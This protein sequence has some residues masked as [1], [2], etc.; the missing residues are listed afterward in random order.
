[1]SIL[2]ALVVMVYFCDREY[3][4]KL[5][6]ELVNGLLGVMLLRRVSLSRRETSVLYAAL[7]LDVVILA[8]FCSVFG[9]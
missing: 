7:L 5:I 3:S 8:F 6:F 9:M 2:L 4:A 1:V